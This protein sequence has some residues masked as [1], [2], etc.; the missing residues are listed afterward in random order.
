[1]L[2][3][4]LF[5]ELSKNRNYDVYATARQSHGLSRWFPPEL[6]RKI[7]CDVD[8]DSFDTVTRVL[9]S[10]QPEIVINCIGLIKQLPLA[11]DPLSSVTINGELPHRLSLICRM[12]DAR[13]IHISTDCVFDG[14]KGH[15]TEN[16]QS[17]ATDL[18]GRS[19]YL[20]EVVYPHC[21]TL[22]TSIIGHELKGKLGLIEWFLVQDTK[23]RGYTNA[24]YTGFPTIELAHII[25]RYVIPSD[26]LS[27]LYH[28]SSE[29]I[30]K[31]ELLRLVMKRY[32]K[33]IEIEPFDDFRSDRSLESS[34]FRTITGY[35]PPSWV[36]LVDI[37]Y[38]DFVTS[39][40][41]RH[42]AE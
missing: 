37:M 26:K 15:Y 16:D 34:L 1:M 32:G 12:A 35:S 36:E 25:D 29:P 28:V 9:E 21:I 39:H 8:A 13:L 38:Q 22:R 33:S 6:L 24:I 11:G 23:V 27:G 5:F 20:G 40:Y 42:S 17:N 31:Y 19:K 4:K 18:Y 14:A 41:Y 7:Q 2:G 30:S 3:H 10:V